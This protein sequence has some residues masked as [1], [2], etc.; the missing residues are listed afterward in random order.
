MLSLRGPTLQKNG[1][2]AKYEKY[3]TLS[4]YDYIILPLKFESRWVWVP[5]QEG[6]IYQRTKFI[7]D[8]ALPPVWGPM[9]FCETSHIVVVR[10]DN[11]LEYLASNIFFFFFFLASNIQL[12]KFRL[13]HFYN[14]ENCTPNLTHLNLFKRWYL[15]LHVSDDRTNFLALLRV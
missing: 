9:N 8:G 7:G 14:L 12:L 6:W 11:V 13:F 10:F 15:M 1:V 3:G 4:Q 2:L 5:N